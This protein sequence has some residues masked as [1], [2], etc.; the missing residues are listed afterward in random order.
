MS[1]IPSTVLFS[2]GF[3]RYRAELQI[4]Q[5]RAAITEGTR[6]NDLGARLT[7]SRGIAF[8]MSRAREAHQWSSGYP[9]LYHEA[10]SLID[11]SQTVRLILVLQPA[12][13]V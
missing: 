9:G 4:V 13:C 5:L 8:D 12:K 6:S 7:S 10:P 2:M 1:S 3:L 11:G